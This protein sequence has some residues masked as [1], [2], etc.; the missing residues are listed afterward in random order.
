MS[1]PL[2]RL[3]E[4]ARAL[5]AGERLQL[6]AELVPD[7]VSDPVSHEGVHRL[8]DSPAQP[9]ARPHAVKVEVPRAPRVSPLRSHRRAGPCW[10][11]GRAA[12]VGS[13]TYATVSR[14]S[15]HT[16]LPYFSVDPQGDL[17]PVASNPVGDAIPTIAA[18]TWHCGGTR[19]GKG[20]VVSHAL[21]RDRRARYA[22]CTMA[23]P[24][25]M[26]AEEALALDAA[27][28][29]QLAAELI[30]SVEGAPDPAWFAVWSDELRRRSEATD[31]RE[32]R[33]AEW[34]AVRERAQ[35]VLSKK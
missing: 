10:A 16:H 8:D 32:V 5:D 34:S 21:P 1:V 31:A 24:L 13:R 33:G 23:L 15:M 9:A 27:E 22:S 4:E 20:A 14:A 6:A 17:G 2:R 12:D 35:R 19:S 18:M 11:A 28:R 3:A 25:R 7:S 29:L 26:L 30:E